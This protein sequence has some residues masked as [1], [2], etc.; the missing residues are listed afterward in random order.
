MT[1]IGEFLPWDATANGQSVTEGGS[2]GS[3]LFNSSGNIIGQLFGGFAGGQP[4]C[5]DPS[6]DEGDY[7]RMDVSW[8]FGATATRRL[9]DHFR[10]KWNRN[11]RCSWKR[12]FYL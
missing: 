5:S 7:G 9:S 11:N 4:N 2:S 6:N 8:N 1:I 10:S 12:W 3:P